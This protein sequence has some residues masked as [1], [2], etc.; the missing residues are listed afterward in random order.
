VRFKDYVDVL[1]KDRAEALAPH[2]PIDHVIDLEPGFDIPYGQ[3]Y[4]LWEV[5]LKTLMAYIETNQAN[6]FIQRSSSPTATPILF[7]KK[8]D[9]GLQLCVDYQ[10]FNRA[11]LKN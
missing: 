10:A 4:N 2:Q 6:G 3:I 1:S 11:T 7:V 5:E 8:E 9:S